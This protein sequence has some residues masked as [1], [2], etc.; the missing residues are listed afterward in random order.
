[1]T[2][3]VNVRILAGVPHLYSPAEEKKRRI[4]QVLEWGC[5]SVMLMVM[6][7][8]NVYTSLGR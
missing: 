6:L 2:R 5:A 8:A 7:A 3:I 4:R 1:V